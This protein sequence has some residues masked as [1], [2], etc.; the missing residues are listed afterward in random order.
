MLFAAD[1]PT[2]DFTLQALLLAGLL[3]N[4]IVAWLAISGRKDAQRR[5]ISFETEFATKEEMRELR[6]SLREMEN[7]LA[8]LKDS[9]VE[10][11]EK[12]RIAIEHK[13]DTRAGTIEHK[14][15]A[16]QETV[17][18]IAVELARQGKDRP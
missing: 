18:K 13:L 6:D 17:G 2:A 1:A 8:H 5:Q 16:L 7:D 12:R 10:N 15:E 14:L 3:G 9:I 11:G 4:A